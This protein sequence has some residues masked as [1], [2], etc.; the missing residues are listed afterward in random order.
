MSKLSA[1]IIRKTP[2]G[3]LAV[4]KDREESLPKKRFIDDMDAAFQDGKYVSPN[5]GP[6]RVKFRDMNNYCKQV[7]KKPVELTDEEMEQFRF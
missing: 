6:P 7:G 3:I 2:S 1:F 5:E 4:R